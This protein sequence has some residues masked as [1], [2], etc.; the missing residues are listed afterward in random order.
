MFIDC[1]RLI[2]TNPIQLNYGVAVTDLDGDGRFE[3]VVAGFGYPN[4][5]LKWDGENL[6]DV[7]TMELADSLRQA[8]GVAAADI[9]GDGQ[10]ELYI[11]NSDTFAGRKQFGDR[12][13]DLTD[14]N[15][16][17]LFALP[18]NRPQSNMTSGRSVIAVDR[19]GEGYYGFYVANYGGPIRLY[20]LDDDGRLRDMAGQARV[21]LRTGGRS[22]VALPLVTEHMDIFA[23]NEGG[24]NYLFRNVGGV[25]EETGADYGVDDPFNHARGVTVVD[26]EE[27]GEFALVYGNWEGHHR[28]FVRDAAGRFVDAAPP[29]MAEPSRVRTVI[30]ADFDNDGCEEIFFNNIGQ[31]NR[32]FARR[33]GGWAS[34]DIG[35]ALEPYGLGTGGAVGD[36][37]ED[38]H[39]ELLIAHGESAMQPLTLYRARPNSNHWLRVLPLTPF[40][41]PARGAV[42]QLEA[43]GR[44]QRRAID[45][46]SGYLC[47]ME[48]VAHFG[49]GQT[50]QID[51]VQVRWL[52]GKVKTIDSPKP[53][54][55]LRVEYPGIRWF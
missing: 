11:L 41:A 39:L 25:F 42:V 34:V 36:F 47:Q 43:G 52:D 29:E 24:P 31:A 1:S 19:K 53:D 46:G 4:L 48:P 21:N 2:L 40:G 8:I 35:D 22:A 23:G 15:W 55:L 37:D 54:S 27:T 10:E 6:R 18:G 7:A 14:D 49:L 17:D 50:R 26:N 20:E 28:L 13:M 33:D 32:L 12:L 44:T 5:I 51:R 45:A 38:G 30:A 9:D 16:I 3:I